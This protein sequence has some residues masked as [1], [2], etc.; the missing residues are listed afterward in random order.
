M[1]LKYVFCNKKQL[2]GRDV[3]DN[4][5]QI[6]MPKYKTSLKINDSIII[7]K[8]L[9]CRKRRNCLVRINF[10]FCHNVFKSCLLQM[11][12]NDSASGKRL[13]PFPHIDAF[14]RHC[15]R[16][17]LKT[18]RQ[19]KKLLIMSNFSFCHNVF[20]SYLKIILSFIEILNI[21]CNTFTKSSAADLLYVRKGLRW[22][23]RDVMKNVVSPML[24]A[25]LIYI[26]LGYWFL[27]VEHSD[28]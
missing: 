19:K 3:I 2:L 21:F 23:D 9:Q 24:C 18:L 28:M 13:N 1:R 26:G 7:E 11:H 20:N 10:S 27:F 16:R 15:N 12:E 25:G 8:K 22:R 4:L 14:W 6:S 5:I 17:L